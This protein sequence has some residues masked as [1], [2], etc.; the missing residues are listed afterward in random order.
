MVEVEESID[1]NNAAFFI[2]VAFGLKM[3]GHQAW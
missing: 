3:I 2:G 1:K